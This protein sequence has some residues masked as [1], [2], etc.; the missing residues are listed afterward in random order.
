[1]VRMAGVEPTT[2]AFGGRKKHIVL[3]DA[4]WRKNDP[5]YN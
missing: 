5:F 3:S 2:L 4:F 1:M